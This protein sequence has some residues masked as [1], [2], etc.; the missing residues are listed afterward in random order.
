MEENNN[1]IEPLKEQ[2]QLPETTNET[3]VKTTVLLEKRKI[4]SKRPATSKKTEKPKWLNT[5]AFLNDAKREKL[6]QVPELPVNIKKSKKKSTRSKSAKVT[7]SEF[8]TTNNKND[9]DDD[10]VKKK[11]SNNDS[12]NESDSE[13][14]LERR[15]S[16]TESNKSKSASDSSTQNS[17]SSKHEQEPVKSLP[18]QTNDKQPTQSKK[19]NLKRPKFKTTIDLD[20]I[21]YDNNF[22]YHDDLHYSIDQALNNLHVST[23]YKNLIRSMKANV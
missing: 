15:G 18:L 1:E 21:N 19:S 17:S 20:K 16:N 5:F 6:M 10:D 7:K 13:K 11:L 12:D 8:K 23:T 3:E 9:D 22:N 14:N 4:L 2:Q